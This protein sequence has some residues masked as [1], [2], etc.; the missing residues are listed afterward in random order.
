LIQGGRLTI[1]LP[2][3]ALVICCGPAGAGKSTFAQRHFSAN[4]IVSSDRC[5]ALIAG[6]EANQAVSGRA[7][8]FFHRIIEHR[9]ALGQLT[10]ADSTAIASRARSEL[11]RLARR[12]GRPVVLLAFDAGLAACFKNNCRRARHVPRA[13][14][15]EQ[16]RR[17]REQGAR[18]ERESYFAVYRLGTRTLGAARVQIVAPG[19]DVAD[20]SQKW[21]AGRGVEANSHRG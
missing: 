8:D 18:F 1:R 15:R 9:L 2:I 11:R 17:F 13:V 7:F 4:Q 12:H 19:A 5:R 3:R 16:R 6:D 10:V 20:E 21:S 14:I